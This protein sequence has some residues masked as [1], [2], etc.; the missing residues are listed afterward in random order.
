MLTEATDIIATITEVAEVEFK[1]G[2]DTKGKNYNKTETVDDSMIEA[3]DSF[4]MEI[5]HKQQILS[6]EKEQNIGKLE[7]TPEKKG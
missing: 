5:E 4:E 2:M 3:M 1:D 6:I 7:D